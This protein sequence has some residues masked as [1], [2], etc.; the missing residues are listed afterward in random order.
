MCDTDVDKVKPSVLTLAKYLRN[1]INLIDNNR[2]VPFRKELE[3]NDEYIALEKIRF[4]DKINISYDIQV[5]DFMLPTFTLQPLIENAIRH[6]IRPKKGIGNIKISTKE[7]ETAYLLI[8]SDD[9]V[10]FRNTI[11]KDGI[12]H[13]G[14]S[15][16]RTRIN[17]LIGGT[18]N[19]NSILGEGTTVTVSIPKRRSEK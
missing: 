7:S 3:Y 11:Q 4:E 19:V 9:G 2:L 17:M 16:I 13:I 14:L 1:N 8:I 12:A 6:G 5:S 15:N 18:V 10:G